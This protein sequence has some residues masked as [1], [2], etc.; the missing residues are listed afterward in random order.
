MPSAASRMRSHAVLYPHGVKVLWIP[1]KS[2]SYQG[3][4]MLRIPRRLPKMASLAPLDIVNSLV[5]VS[6]VS[7]PLCYSWGNESL[8]FLL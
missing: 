6:V 4:K 5:I 8:M 7:L 1:I 3:R 2:N